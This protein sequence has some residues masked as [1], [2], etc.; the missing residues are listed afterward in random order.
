[1][2]IMAPEAVGESLDPRDPLL[3][4]S[5]FFD[6]NSVELFPLAS[7]TVLHGM[8]TSSRMR[9]PRAHAP[10]GGLRKNRAAV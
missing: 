2:T 8:S 10:L 4:L 9:S 3:R 5:A 6:D 1:M 7:W